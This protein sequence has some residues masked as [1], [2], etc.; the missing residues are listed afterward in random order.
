[1]FAS[2]AYRCCWT[3]SRKSAL[4]Y[5]SNVLVTP[6]QPSP[7]SQDISLLTLCTPCDQFKWPPVCKHTDNGV[8]TGDALDALPY[9]Q[10]ARL[11]LQGR[12]RAAP[13]RRAASS[14][15]LPSGNS[16][17]DRFLQALT[18]AAAA[19]ALG[20]RP[21]HTWLPSL[22]LLVLRRGCLVC[23]CIPCYKARGAG[24]A[25][26]ARRAV[27]QVRDLSA[28]AI[29]AETGRIYPPMILIPYS[30]A[31]QHATSYC[32]Y[33]QL[34]GVAQAMPSVPLLHRPAEPC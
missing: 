6:F 31:Q 3:H 19:A 12:P 11:S 13:A 4:P 16:S 20:S 9:L 33:Q 34:A 10:L 25:P 18:A 28:R 29:G 14:Q 8:N 30:V 21:G 5:C 24:G 17:C 15:P 32:H 22:S 26:A 27:S 2:A 23:V 7:H 1:V